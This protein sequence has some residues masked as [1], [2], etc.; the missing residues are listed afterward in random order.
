MN[1]TL[2]KWLQWTLGF[3]ILLLVLLLVVPWMIHPNQYRAPLATLVKGM[4]GRQLTIAGDLGLAVFPSLE[5]V[6]RDLSLADAPGFGE[7]P[8]AKVETL[9][10][11]VK[12]IPLLSGRLEVDRAEMKGLILRLQRA[13]DGRT[14]WEE[15]PGLLQEGGRKIASPDSPAAESRETA[16]VADPRGGV[17]ALIGRLLAMSAG[18]V[19]ISSAT[20]LWRD[21]S[22]DVTARVDN[23]ELKTGPIHPGRPVAVTTGF[24]FKE[25]RRGLNGRADLKYQLRGASAG[26]VW[27]D[28]LEVNVK[29]ALPGG[30]IKEAKARFTADLAMDWR[31]RQAEWNRMELATTLWSD[32]EGVRELQMGLQGRM[33][34]DLTSGRLAI[35]K[36]VVTMLLKGNTL[37]PAG[38]QARLAADVSG[39]PRARTFYMDNLEIDGP[40]GIHLQGDVRTRGWWSGIE[41]SLSARRFDFRALLIALGRTIP[42]SPDV[43]ACPGAEAE[44]DFV[45]DAEGVKLPRVTLGLDDT[46]LTGSFSY[47][48]HG[49]KVQF[50][51][52]VDSLEPERFRPLLAGTGLGVWPPEWIGPDLV[53]DGAVQIGRVG[54]EKGELVGLNLQM[55]TR[56]GV[57]R[58]DPLSWKT[59]GGSVSNLVE[60]DQREAESRV[61]LVQTLEGVHL[62]PMFQDLVGWNGLDG[63]GEWVV[64]LKGQGR[65][66]EALIRSLSGEIRLSV[67]DGVVTG[68]DVGGRIRNAHAVFNRQRPAAQTGGE[69]TRFSQL[70]AMA[71]VRDGVVTGQELEMRGPALKVSGGGQVDLVKRRV[72]WQWNG[73]VVTVLQ[74]G[75]TDADRYAGLTLPIQLRGPFDGL[76]KFEVGTV[77]FSRVTP[78][79]GRERGVE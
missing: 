8:M 14:N 37:P 73:D 33:E 71:T 4:T 56:E 20:V 59:H 23:L 58:V 16:P 62:G 54:L 31:A 52:S 32:G 36:S 18:S 39:D 75:V 44:V 9:V 34:M 72:E 48:F 42:S 43:K 74:G 67:L 2:K 40:A 27:L 35:P 28:G 6:L 3:L 70:T 65:D 17:E 24:H 45:W 38:V 50:N 11:G 53:I 30:A 29:T 63:V 41:G 47:N 55:H 77:D 5:L 19:E 60:V 26:R 15:M 49:P 78:A 76:K 12:F 66:W 1:R 46:H 21:A 61:S 25:E 13:G 64:Q 51:G 7:E 22:A 68:V 79:P 69:E 10:M 57:M